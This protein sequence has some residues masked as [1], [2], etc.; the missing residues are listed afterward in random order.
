M[1]KRAA[2]QGKA[3]PKKQKLPST[4]AELMSS[5][6]PEMHRSPL[7]R[8]SLRQLIRILNAVPPDSGEQ[9]A[10]SSSASR[11]SDSSSASLS[12]SDEDA[13]P[14]EFIVNYRSLVN[15]TLSCKAFSLFMLKQQYR[16]G[17]SL[18]AEYRCA[19]NGLK[20]SSFTY[21]QEYANNV[22]NASITAKSESAEKLINHHWAPLQFL[23]NTVGFPAC[24]HCGMTCGD[25]RGKN[26]VP[27]SPYLVLRGKLKEPSEP[28][29][30]KEDPHYRKN[31][32]IL[33]AY[34]RNTYRCV[35]PSCGQDLDLMLLNT[36]LGTVFD[37]CLTT[38]GGKNKHHVFKKLKFQIYKPGGS[39]K[40]LDFSV[41]FCSRCGVLTTGKENLV[42][43]VKCTG[44]CEDVKRSRGLSRKSACLCDSECKQCKWPVRKCICTFCDSCR[45]CTGEECTR[46]EKL[47]ECEEAYC[48]DCG[49]DLDKCEC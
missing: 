20:K 23:L 48:S 12:S 16:E 18:L 47:C 22:V 44:Q 5:V 41:K 13:A 9:T 2:G 28:L 30:K 32:A 17:F 27:I 49:C 38:N 45:L 40:E 34:R 11:S 25:L 6:H 14:L 29:L 15:L 21:L 42:K 36:P 24:R 31:R 19:A 4:V 46:C 1:S 35:N 39:R 33:K 37:A 3:E 43:E 8:L 10:R 26:G 7:M